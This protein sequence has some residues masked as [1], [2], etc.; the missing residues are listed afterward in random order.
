[1]SHEKIT[2]SA[3]F[4]IGKTRHIFSPNVNLTTDTYYNPESTKCGHKS[5]Y[6]NFSLVHSFSFWKTNIVLYCIISLMKLYEISAWDN[7]LRF[8]IIKK[9]QTLI[10]LPSVHFEVIIS[11]IYFMT[12]IHNTVK[13]K[14]FICLTLIKRI[15]K[16]IKRR[17][18]GPLQM[19]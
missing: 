3:R 17:N 5:G 19:S 11:L 6:F 1:M 13:N 8:R 4:H 10:R 2:H 14:I 18:R 15:P 16:G 12:R 9:K 7:V